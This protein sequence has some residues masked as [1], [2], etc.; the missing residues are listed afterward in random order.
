MYSFARFVTSR[1]GAL[2]TGVLLGS[3][4]SDRGG[5]RGGWALPAGP[6]GGRGGIG[7]GIGPPGGV[8]GARGA[9]PIGGIRPPGCAGG[10]PIGLLGLCLELKL[11]LEKFK[12]VFDFLICRIISCFVQ[13]GSLLLSI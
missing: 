10:A 12:S 4:G 6:Y 11:L 2:T 5:K 8:G 7:G 3:G 1:I 9:E 13:T